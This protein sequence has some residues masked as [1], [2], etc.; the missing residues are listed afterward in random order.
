MR[1]VIGSV[2]VTLIYCSSSNGRSIA[3]LDDPYV[4]SNELVWD[5]SSKV[6]LIINYK[7]NGDFAATLRLGSW[8]HDYAEDM[9]ILAA[10]LW[11]N[12]YTE[13]VYA[14]YGVGLNLDL[15]NA[16]VTGD[17][18]GELKYLVKNMIV[19]LTD[20]LAL[21]GTIQGERFS[22]TAFGAN[23][24]TFGLETQV[25]LNTDLSIKQISTNY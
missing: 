1:A 25:D 14:K 19:I 8:N 12:I 21:G 3:P 20:K 9:P 18:K 6:S 10:T 13:F 7:E 16:V 4:W 23:L 5:S 11:T 15:V 2:L 22:I 17:T 24:L